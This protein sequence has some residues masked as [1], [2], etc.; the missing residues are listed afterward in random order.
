[1]RW[2]ERR[3]QQ[4]RQWWSSQVLAGFPGLPSDVTLHHSST[5]FLVCRIACAPFW[6][7]KL[8]EGGSTRHVWRVFVGFND[9]KVRGFKKKNKL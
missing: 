4:E 6:L 7:S 9:F 5:P 8:P 1:M 3:G 2:M